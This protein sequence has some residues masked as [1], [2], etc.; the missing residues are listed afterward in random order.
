MSKFSSP[1]HHHY[2]QFYGLADPPHTDDTTARVLVVGNCQ[3]EATRQ[4]LSTAGGHASFRIPPIHEW[5]ADDLT[6]ITELLA[7]TDVLVMQPVRD[8][9]RGL[10][11]GTSQLA[12]HLPSHATTITYPVIRYDGLMPYH[13]IIRS[14][15]D[16]SLNPPVVPYHDLRV[17]AAAARGVDKEEFWHHTAS[18]DTLRTLAAMSVDQLRRRERAH[19][20]I[21]VAH[22]LETAPIFH[23]I[24]HPDND[25]LAVA[26]QAIADAMVQHS[27]VRAT[28]RVRTPE[29]EL[30]GTLKAPIDRAAASA[31]GVTVAGRDDWSPPA[32]GMVS[33]HLRFYREHPDIIDAGLTRHHDRLTL[34]GLLPDRLEAQP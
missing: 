32:P 4:V 34:L 21:S 24:N 28:A 9:Y 19:R 3:A 29:R 31:L 20:T 14:P 13:A 25:T 7:H 16:P 2:G 10:A 33:A 6:R 17:L 5:D 27:G 1:R 11:C 15:V 18:P 23:T 22:H 26:A 8:N 30:L 12:A